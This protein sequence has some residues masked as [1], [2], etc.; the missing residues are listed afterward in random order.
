MQAISAGVVRTFAVIPRAGLRP[1]THVMH[2]ALATLGRPLAAPAGFPDLWIARPRWWQTWSKAS[3]PRQALI[4]S[5]TAD[6]RT[7]C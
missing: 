2:L 1:F 4:S 5:V 7:S 6:C 3:P